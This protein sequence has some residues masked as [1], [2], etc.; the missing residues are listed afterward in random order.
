MNGRNILDDVIY[1][2]VVML[3]VITILGYLIMF[4]C[5]IF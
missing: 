3:G 4:I 1:F 2:V 5:K